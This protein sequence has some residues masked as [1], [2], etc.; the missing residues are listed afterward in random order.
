MHY[1]LRLFDFFNEHVRKE[2]SVDELAQIWHCSTRYAK[3]I[4]KKMQ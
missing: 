1:E 3:T 2:T 4:V